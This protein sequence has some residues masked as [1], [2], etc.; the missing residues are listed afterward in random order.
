MRSSSQISLE[1]IAARK[2]ELESFDKAIPVLVGRLTS[3]RTT[4]R[5][6]KLALYSLLALRCTQEILSEHT[7]LSELSVAIVDAAESSIMLAQVGLD[8]S[9]HVLCR[10][11][12]EVT[13]KV[14]YFHYHPRELNLVRRRLDIRDLTPSTIA[15]FIKKDMLLDTDEEDV[16]VLFD[17]Y[18]DLYALFSRHVH[19]HNEEFSSFALVSDQRTKSEIDGLLAKIRRTLEVSIAITIAYLPEAFQNLKRSEKQAISKSFVSAAPRS[20]V[21]KVFSS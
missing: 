15:E 9:V 4:D 5:E 19:V 11:I 18:S 3:S 16:L 8:N 1:L 2:A 7:S 17:S 13:M 6:L 21:K 12:L 14:L 20:V 10:Q